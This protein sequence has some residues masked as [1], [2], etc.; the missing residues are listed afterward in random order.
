V[1]GA[2]GD[3]LIHVEVAVSDLEVEAAVR[4]GADP[5]L[6]VN[7]GTLAP[8]VRKWYQVSGLALLTFREIAE[9]HVCHQSS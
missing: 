5:G 9:I 8:E 4:I 6:E 2:G 1:D 7:G 3:G